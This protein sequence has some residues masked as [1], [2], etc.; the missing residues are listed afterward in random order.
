MDQGNENNEENPHSS[1]RPLSDPFFRL[2]HQR[3]PITAKK[4]A[5]LHFL[6]QFLD[7]K[8]RGLY[9]APFEGEYDTDE[10][11]ETDFSSGVDEEDSDS[12]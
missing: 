5:H 2:Y 6:S 8:Y 11:A 12:E 9:P 1:S 3:R 4:K 7:E 10:D